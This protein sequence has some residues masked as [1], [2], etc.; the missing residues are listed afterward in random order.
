[1]YACK[2][3]RGENK[4]EGTRIKGLYSRTYTYHG[5]VVFIPFR[6]RVEIAVNIAKI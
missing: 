5:V 1:M 2:A 6:V 4:T 3:K